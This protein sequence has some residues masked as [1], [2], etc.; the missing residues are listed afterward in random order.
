M[1]LKVRHLN[2]FIDDE[3]YER[4]KNFN[5]GI[6]V[7]KNV[8]YIQATT[9]APRKTIQLARLI[10]NAEAGYLIDHV[11][12]DTLDNRKE[13][14]RAASKKTN[15]QNMK[16]NA[17]TT[18]KYKGVCWDKFRNK[19]RASIK[20]NNRQCHIGRFNL[21]EEAAK[22]YDI[23]AKEHFGEFARTNFK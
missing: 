16:P 15:A 1:I 21:E 5:W 19:W 7:K 13:N 6:A 9:K 12:G 4:I 11:N 8:P 18:S 14:L 17:N 20:V 2:V 3:D 10:M 22:A 23:K